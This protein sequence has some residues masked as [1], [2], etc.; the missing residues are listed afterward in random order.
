[1]DRLRLGIVIPAFNE[2]RAIVAVVKAASAFGTV[3]VVDD[4]SSDSTA[5]VAAAH[6]ALVVR[7]ATN[8]GYDRALQAGAERARALGCECFITM[9]ADGQHDPSRIEIF[10]QQI[11]SGADVVVGVRDRFQRFSEWLFA[12][13]GRH[14]WRIEDPLC[15]MK[16]YRMAV[17]DALGHFDSYQSIGTELAIYAARSGRTIRNVP[18]LTRPRHGASRFGSGWRAN[19]R[20][21]RALALALFR[22]PRSAVRAPE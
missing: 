22:S 6:G 11:R 1:V 21:L 18:I 14:L 19:M 8:G 7:Q 12:V 17:Y 3:I 5:E 4:A 15:G 10:M 16:C 20:I 2:A 13:V 9:D